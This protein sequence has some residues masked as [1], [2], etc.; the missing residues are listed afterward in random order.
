MKILKIQKLNVVKEITE[1]ELPYY[2]DKGYRQLDDK[3]NLVEPHAVSDD[4]KIGALE[5]KVKELEAALAASEAKVK[6][7]EAAAENTGAEDT[8]TTA[9][10][11]KAAK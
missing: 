6:E 2:E 3:G 7:L 4:V 9:A 10:E 11:K 1:K 5:A 8:G